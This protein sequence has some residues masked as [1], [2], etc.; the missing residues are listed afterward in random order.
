LI[1]RSHPVS[2]DQVVVLNADGDRL[3]I[4]HPVR[5]SMTPAATVVASERLKLVEPEQ[6]AQ[7]RQL[8]IDGTA[9]VLLD[10]PAK[11]LFDSAG[12]LRGGQGFG[13]I[14]IQASFIVIVPIGTRGENHGGGGRQVQRLRSQ[15]ES[16]RGWYGGHH[17]E[18]CDTHGVVSSAAG[19]GGSLSGEATR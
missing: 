4:A 12:E 15:S 3:R 2:T 6:P 17:D 10:F 1:S 13:Q 18:R 7:I 11:R 8:R 9:Q 14:P 19:R 16:G 5:R